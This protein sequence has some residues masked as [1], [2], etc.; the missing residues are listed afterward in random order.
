MRDFWEEFRDQ[1]AWDLLPFPFLYDLY[2]NWFKRVSPSGS[3]VGRQLFI[4]DLVGLLTSDDDWF[5]KPKNAQGKHPA[6]RPGYLMDEPEPLIA[7]YEVTTWYSPVYKGDDPLQARSPAHRTELPRR[8]AHRRVRVRADARHQRR[9][10]GRSMTTTTHISPR[11]WPVAITAILVAI[12]SVISFGMSFV[13]MRDLMERAGFPP[14]EVA[15]GIAGDRRRHDRRGDG[16]PVRSPWRGT[17]RP[18]GAVGLAGRV[19]RHLRDL[20]RRAHLGDLQ[21]GPGIPLAFAIF[22]G[23]LPPVALL[24]GSSELLVRS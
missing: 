2:K 9:R 14:G 8:P 22:L 21:R 4:S 19:R 3:V 18:C 1:F 15:W 10:G 7:E 6:T 13:A 11:R 24:G 12:I 17:R 23:T 20:Q 16:L 5:T